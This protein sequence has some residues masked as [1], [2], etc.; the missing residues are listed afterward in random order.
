[1]IEILVALGVVLGLVF[2]VYPVYQSV[3]GSAHAVECTGN[4]RH[5]YQSTLMFIAD[6]DGKLFPDLGMGDSGKSDTRTIDSRFSWNRYWFDTPYLGRYVLDEM[7]RR[8]DSPGRIKQ[9]ETG[10]YNC[11]SRLQEGPDS[12][13]TSGSNPGISYVMRKMYLKP[14]NYLFHAIENK[15]RKLLYTEGRKY[16]LATS[17]A[18]TGWKSGTQRLRRFHNDNQSLNILY[19]DGRVELFSGEDEDIQEKVRW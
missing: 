4:L 7:K 5:L 6:Y 14:E 10:F 2:L 12:E 1:M 13:F 15:E 3:R 9:S 8:L 16:S 17:S 18:Y 19:M 11:P